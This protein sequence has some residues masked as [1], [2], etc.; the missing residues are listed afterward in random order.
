MFSTEGI[1]EFFIF[2][3]WHAY[4]DDIFQAHKA[5]LPPYTVQ[6]LS[7][8]G[9]TVTDLLIQAEGGR[10]NI[11]NTHWQQSDLNLAKGRPQ[12]FLSTIMNVMKIF[13]SAKE[14]ISCL[15]AMFSQGKQFRTKF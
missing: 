2:T 14:W 5:Q 1:T 12:R 3:R 10:P 7:Y 6:Q 11:I 4:I 15:E 8:P 9:I 13:A